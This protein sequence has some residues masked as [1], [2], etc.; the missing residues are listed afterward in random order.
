MGEHSHHAR[1]QQLDDD[2]IRVV[3]DVAGQLSE[4]ARCER[5][6]ALLREGAN[7]NCRDT[8]GKTPLIYAAMGRRILQRNE[9]P[10]LMET[11]LAVPG[12]DINAEDELGCNALHMAMYCPTK[13]RARQVSLLL[14]A[15]ISSMH[16]NNMMQ[17]PLNVAAQYGN[18]NEMRQLLQHGVKMSVPDSNNRTPLETC[19]YELEQART[20]KGN[21]PNEK[22]HME[23]RLEPIRVIA[24]ELEQ[25]YKTVGMLKPPL[26]EIMLLVDMLGEKIE[27]CK[28]PFDQSFS[29]GFYED[30]H[31]LRSMANQ[32]EALEKASLPM[33]D[34]EIGSRAFGI[35]HKESE[36]LRRLKDKKP[37]LTHEETENARAR[38]RAAA[39][40]QER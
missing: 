26:D 35:H 17:D 22:A 32:I 8:L 19:I 37:A 30:T 38:R 24:E 31:Q 23:S 40:Q 15:G 2:L 9:T 33:L 7:I 34:M 12:I 3:H 4:R 18:T 5:V 39:R 20:D 29:R 10:M 1:Q 36:A 11:L 27:N 21:M 6:A 13:L 25:R 28:N 16:Q 14:E